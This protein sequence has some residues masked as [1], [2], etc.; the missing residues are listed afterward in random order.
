MLGCGD[1]NIYVH[2]VE[3]R[4]QLNL[5]TGHKDYVHS[6]DVTD[7]SGGISIVSGGED[8]AVKLWDTRYIQTKRIV[9]NKAISFLF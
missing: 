6:V 5:L 1:R 8:G 9:A 7:G 2:D 4:D 3:T